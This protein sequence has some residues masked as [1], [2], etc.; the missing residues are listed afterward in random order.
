M[1]QDLLVPDLKGL[2]DR[3]RVLEAEIDLKTIFLA[4]SVDKRL[5]ALERDREHNAPSAIDET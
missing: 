3:L 2:Q 4:L 5:E 1:I